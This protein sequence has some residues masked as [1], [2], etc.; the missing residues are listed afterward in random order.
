MPRI[1]LLQQVLPAPV[2]R[3]IARCWYEAERQRVLRSAGHAIGPELFAMDRAVP[4]I[5]EGPFPR[6]VD[7]A[8]PSETQRA[9][10][11]SSPATMQPEV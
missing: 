1:R 3:D 8:L 10:R 7:N 5:D 2:T 9:E 11:I 6:Y 4:E